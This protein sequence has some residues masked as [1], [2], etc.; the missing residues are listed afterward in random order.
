MVECDLPKVDVVGSNPIAR[1]A[2]FDSPVFAQTARCHTGVQRSNR[3]PG[4]DWRKAVVKVLAMMA[5][6]SLLGGD[7]L[8]DPWENVFPELGEIEVRTSY[9]AS[10][11][12]SWSLDDIELLDPF[13][14]Q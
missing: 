14:H 12:G 10:D 11:S 6:I 2:A 4:R 3:Y 9:V 8:L 1:S 13:E 5:W 7:P